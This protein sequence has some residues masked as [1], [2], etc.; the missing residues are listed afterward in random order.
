MRLPRWVPAAAAFVVLVVVVAVLPSF[1][2][3]FPI[4][5]KWPL[6]AVG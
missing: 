5:P 6:G 3:S 1:V 2:S 4:P